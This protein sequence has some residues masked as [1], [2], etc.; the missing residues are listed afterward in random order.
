MLLGFLFLMG[1][2]H[3][4]VVCLGENQ[5]KHHKDT[6]LKEVELCLQFFSDKSTQLRTQL[7]GSMYSI[8]ESTNMHFP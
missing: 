8:K 7:G 5:I 1:H 6:C 3:L 2:L 4:I